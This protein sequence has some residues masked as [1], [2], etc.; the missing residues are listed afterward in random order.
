MDGD[1]KRIFRAN[2]RSRP[3]LLGNCQLNRK[4]IFEGPS[5]MFTLQFGF[6]KQS[7]DKETFTRIKNNIISLWL[8][9]FQDFNFV[10]YF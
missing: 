7:L 4:C 3:R 1:Y 2:F 8:C 9:T 6:F 10:S 5:I